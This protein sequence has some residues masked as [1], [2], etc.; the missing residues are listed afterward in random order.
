MLQAGLRKLG[1]VFALLLPMSGALAMPPAEAFA[2]LPTFSDL[3]ISPDGH[4]LATRMNRDGRYFL[5]ILDISDGQPKFVHSLAEDDELSVAWFE[6]VSK[7]HL[8]ASLS[9]TGKR[10]G[11]G[12]VKTDERRLFAINATTKE[13]YGLFRTKRDEIPI[14]IQD[15]IVSFLATDPDHILV[16][17]SSTNPQTPN[18]HKVNVT[19]ATRHPV[20][21]R[22]RRGVSRWMADSDGD[23]RLGEGIKNEKDPHL[24]VRE[25]S[26]KKWKDL[27]HR[28]EQPGVTFDPLAFAK[29]S[30]LI[31]VR[32]NHEGD[33]MGL[34]TFDI[35]RD[36]FVELI[37]KH[38]TVDVASIR[39]DATTSELLS[40]NFVDDDVETVRFLVRPIQAEIR[41]FRDELGDYGVSTRAVSS[42]GSHAVILISG[43]TDAG[44]FYVFDAA[45]NSAF[46]LP[47]QYPDLENGSLGRTFV[48][49]YLARDGLTIPAFVTLP[50]G[51][52]SLDEIEKIPFIVHPHGGPNA[53]DFL[54]FSYKIQFLVSRGYGV[55]QMNFRG[56]TGYGQA[57]KDAG[58]REWGQAMQDDVTDGAKWLIENNYADPDRIAIVGASYGGYAALMGAVKTP[59]LYQCAVSFA[60]VSDLPRLLSHERKFLFGRYKTRFI[61]DL[62]KDR[63]ML[64]ANSPAQRAEEIKIPVLLLHGDLDTS[65]DIDQSKRMAKQL[66]KYDKEYKFVELENGDHYSSLYTNRLRYLQEMERFLDGCLK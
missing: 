6:W 63:K 20:A 45:A 42:D 58:N 49:E 17:Y 57:F 24:A 44:T 12:V 66:R 28:L 15:R 29:D 56:S 59:D 16:Q 34:Y 51:I 2:R 37:Y 39:L 55:L 32:S 10:R 3:E 14:Q 25:K 52:E 8:V 38:P 60:G 48:T 22:G 11:R 43:K 5:I 36:E 21:E 26:A 50:P 65:V 40:A 23:V 62:W 19:K 47:A 46:S 35:A 64:A 61:G 27:S 9:F 30:D 1:I 53:R 31:Y 7:E 13:T 4:F 33:P 41:R 54:R 18:V